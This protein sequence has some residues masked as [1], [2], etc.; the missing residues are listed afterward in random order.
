MYQPLFETGITG[1]VVFIKPQRKSYEKRR[2]LIA[3]DFNNLLTGVTANL[4]LA[5][6]KGGDDEINRLLKRTLGASDSAIDLT[7][8]LLTFAEGGAPV[9]KLGSVTDI[10]R[11]SARFSLRGAKVACQFEMEDAAWA[12][13]VD[14]GQLS[15]VI[16]N[17]VINADQSMP[18]G[19]TLSLAV[20]NTEFTA[21]YHALEA[22]R[23]LTITI[24]DEGV[25]IPKD[26]IDRIFDPYFTTKQTGNGLGLA[27][28]HSIITQHGGRIEVS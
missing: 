23:Y 17:L 6:L 2:Y 8:Q 21:L 4:S 16:S 19:G 13:E 25:G 18:K 22:G 26:C 27:T 9:K 15:Q 24:A 20:K 28:V 3:H 10:V 11:E 12:A 5:L 7:R 1:F 14:A